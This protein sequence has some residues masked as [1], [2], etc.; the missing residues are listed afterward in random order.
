[1]LDNRNMAFA[2]RY[3]DRTLEECRNTIWN[4][5]LSL[6]ELRRPV[7]KDG[8]VFCPMCGKFFSE[9][10]AA[11]HPNFCENC[12]QAFDWPELAGQGDE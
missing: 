8:R 9:A 2:Q 6:V 10:H 1:M 4:R 7:Y 3:I 5:L 12:G 11:D